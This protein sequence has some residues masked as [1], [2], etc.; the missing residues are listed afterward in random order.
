M[1]RKNRLVCWKWLFLI[2]AGCLCTST[3]MAVNTES[4]RDDSYNS[5]SQGELQSVA[6]TSNGYLEPAYDRRLLGVTGT[7]LIWD[8]LPGKD[9]SMLC[10]TGHGGQLVR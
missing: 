10:A 8:M 1:R 4:I 7:E 3:L 5:L 9:G 6:L 2:L